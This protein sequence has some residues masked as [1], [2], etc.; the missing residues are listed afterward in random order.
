MDDLKGRREA[1]KR[2]L[3]TTGTLGVLQAGSRLRL[4]SLR[5]VL[6]RLVLTNFYIS[7]ILVEELIRD[8]EQFRN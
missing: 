6:P 1:A 5:E 2:G 4:V 7:S 8:E 3:R